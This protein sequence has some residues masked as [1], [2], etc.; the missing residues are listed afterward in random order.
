MFHEQ[1][2]TFSNET[3]IAGL[4]CGRAHVCA[5]RACPEWSDFR[6]P[7]S[8]HDRRRPIR[9]YNDD[10]L[11]FPRNIPSSGLGFIKWSAG[12]R[13]RAYKCGR[14][15]FRGR[16]LDP[17]PSKFVRLC[18]VRLLERKSRSP[19]L[20]RNGYRC[21]RGNADLGEYVKLSDLARHRGT[22]LLD[23]ER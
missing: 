10:F 18:I 3:R 11:V 12:K 2:T 13:L 23:L 9:V 21:L 22:R 5:A 4:L 8:V 6:K 1:T 19:A 16:A 17:R 7:E 14:T 20:Q 15:I